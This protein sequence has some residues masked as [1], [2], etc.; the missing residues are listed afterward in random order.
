MKIAVLSTPSDCFLLE[1][2]GVCREIVFGFAACGGGGG[3]FDSLNI[4][5]VELLCELICELI[6]RGFLDMTEADMMVYFDVDENGG[7][8]VR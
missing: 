5:L 7:G 1:G 6:W 4:V 8:K 2:A 3:G